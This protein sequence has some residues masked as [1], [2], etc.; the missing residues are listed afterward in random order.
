MWRERMLQKA[1]DGCILMTAKTGKDLPVIQSLWIGD[2]LSV[3][4]RLCIA[5][6]LD[7]GHAFHL[8]T[9]D[10]VQNVPQG[11]TVR[12]ASE[13]IDPNRIF[14]YNQRDSY[15]GFA[16]LFRYKLLLEKG[17]Y[18]V[19]ADIICIKP[20]D[21]PK[22]NV[23]SGTIKRSRMN[24]FNVKT[25]VQNCVISTPV[26]SEIMNYCYDIASNKDSQKLKWGETGPD[27]L[28][29]AVYK[30]GMEDYVLYRAFSPVTWEDWRNLISGSFLVSWI[31]RAK[32]ELYG[33]HAIHLYNEMWRM[34]GVDKN[35][36]F[37]PASVYEWLK[38]R[39]SVGD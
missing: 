4:E 34:E 29:S 17:G 3:M 39:Y 24:P 36:V 28:E 37:P 19:D 16:N 30:F 9:Y 22:E 12:D 21:F 10:G 5:S 20:F 33:S 2:K 14:K 26:G 11:T 8:Y 7:N 35:A 15:A 27:L 32:L 1:S 6:F 31:Q 13:I 23:F 38:N 25:H 18:W